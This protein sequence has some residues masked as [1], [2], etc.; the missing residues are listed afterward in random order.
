MEIIHRY[1]NYLLLVLPIVFVALFF[2]NELIYKR[3][4]IKDL[5]QP[6][7]NSIKI[8]NFIA[9]TFALAAMVITFMELRGV[10]SKLQLIPGKTAWVFTLICLDITQSIELVARTITAG[11]PQKKFIFNTL[12]ERHKRTT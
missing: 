12:P 6:I 11:K 4:K 10:A 9:I 8:I 7:K 5:N 3:A 2:W 1:T